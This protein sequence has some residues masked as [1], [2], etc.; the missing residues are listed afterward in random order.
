M[1]GHKL[2]LFFLH[3]SFFG[4]YLLEVFTLGIA[5]LYV[6]PYLNMAEAVFYSRL[7]Y[8]HKETQFEGEVYEEDE[9][10]DDFA[11]Y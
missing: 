7:R 9:E 2:E 4:W 5:S 8:D 10:Y 11:D 3:L 6:R 1:D